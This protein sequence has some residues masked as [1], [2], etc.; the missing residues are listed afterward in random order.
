M[1]LSALGFCGSCVVGF[2]QPGAMQGSQSPALKS[3]ET[4]MVLA[5]VI[6]IIGV[7]VTCV[8]MFLKRNP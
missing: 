6:F 5:S 7:V 3:A 1:M 8:G 4:G 2:G